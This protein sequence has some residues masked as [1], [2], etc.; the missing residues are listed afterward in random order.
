[1][2]LLGSAAFFVWLLVFAREPLPQALYR[3]MT[4]LVVASPC[5]LVLSIP[6]AILVAIAAGARNGILFRGGVAV[7]TLAAVDHFAFDKTGTLTTGRL[8]ISRIA[9]T[10]SVTEN[11]LLAL[12]ASIAAASTHPLSRAIAEEGKSRGLTNY[13]PDEITNIPGFGVRA[14]YGSDDVL[15]GS[16]K[17]MEQ[18]GI[19]TAA[20][21]NT[22]A[23]A[24]VWIARR[25]LLGIIYL[26][27]E[28][29]SAAPAALA[30]LRAAGKYTPISRLTKS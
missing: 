14:R 19:D 23:E 20:L 29:R 22:S 11:E 16:R 26:K 3:M 17:F 9:T 18:S 2:I 7:E 8:R 24:E 1:M 10:E 25:Q 12:A 6:S 4:L 21:E 13:A 28:V 27:D 5:A 15:M 30:A